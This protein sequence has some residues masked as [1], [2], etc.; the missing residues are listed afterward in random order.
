[1]DTRMGLQAFIGAKLGLLPTPLADML[2]YALMSRSLAV[3]GEFD[4][5]NRLAE[6][7]L[8]AGELATEINADER[9]VSLLLAVLEDMGY[10]KRR[11]RKSV[12]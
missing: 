5:F 4:I 11:G 6:R 10:L 7:P 9:G 2:F 12:A 3:A 8:T 1:M